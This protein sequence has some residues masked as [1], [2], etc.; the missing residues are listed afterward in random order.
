MVA[1]AVDRSKKSI[2]NEQARK[3]DGVRHHEP[4]GGLVPDQLGASSALM[5]AH[6]CNPAAWR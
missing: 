5:L 1:S 4:K 6:G 2:A 3:T